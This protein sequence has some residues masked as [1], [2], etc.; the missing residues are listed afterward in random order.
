MTNMDLTRR[1][2]VVTTA[3]AGGGLM[4]G[5]S[6]ALSASAA[7]VNVQPWLSPTEKDGTE[8]NQWVAIDPE[9]VVTV[10]AGCSEMGQGVFTSIPQM[11]AE[12]LQVDWNMVRAQYVD[13]TRHVNN[14]NLYGRTSTTASQVVRTFRIPVQQAG[15]S[16]RERLKAAAATAWGVDRS[17]V[18]AKDGVLSSGNRTGT[19]GEFANAAAA[20]QLPEEPAIKTPDQ[21]TL[22]GTSLARLDTPLKVNGSAQFGIDARLPGM[23]YATVQTC[24]VQSGSLRSFDFDAVKDR[25]GV[26]QAVELR[27]VEGATGRDA[28]TDGVAVVAD[29]WYRAKT[30]LELMPIEWDF[31]PGGNSSNES[32]FAERLALL[33]MPGE[34]SVEGEYNRGDALGVIANGSNVVTAE[35]LRPYEAHA[36]ME[37]MNATVSV[38]GSRADLYVGSQNF[39]SA[40]NIVADQTGVDTTNVQVHALFLGGGFGRRGKNEEVRQAAEIARQVGLPVKMVWTREEDFLQSRPRAMG[41]Q[42]FSAAIGPNGLP[43]ALFI[44]TVGDLRGVWSRGRGRELLPYAVPNEYYDFHKLTSHIPWHYLRG[45]WYGLF[46]FAVESFVDEMA[47]AGGWDPLEFRIELTKHL[48]DEQLVLNTLKEKAGFTLDLPRGEGMGIGLHQEAQTMCA[49]C[50]TVSVS[51][52]GQLRV[53]K[54]VWS[55]NPGHV[56][57]PHVAVEQVESATIYELSSVLRT[58]LEIRNGRVM[59]NNFDTFQIARIGDTPEIEVH[60]AL[61]RGE[62]WGGMGEPGT[63][64]VGSSIANAIFQATG[65][66]IRSTPFKNHDLSWS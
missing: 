23:V 38:G 12:E 48:P 58:G 18:A 42:R 37:P 53:E 21:Y 63:G 61:T 51:R 11:L 29:T 46:G 8:I 33:D 6:A 59:N 26:I 2:F 19:F 64:A 45:V 14:D 10:R 32:L 44:R 65:K 17:Q 35:Y 40:L 60:F 55:V 56:L 41:V 25:P 16:A 66:R 28:L 3:A 20:I 49:A 7:G 15:A 13:Y 36:P 4:L 47:L 50:S 43:E 24:P 39:A 54:M 52:R 5:V 31:G 22:I 34:P 30:A 57:N 1:T 27:A 9:G 62:R